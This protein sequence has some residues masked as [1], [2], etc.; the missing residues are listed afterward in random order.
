MTAIFF[1][2]TGES[3]FRRK[4]Y[5]CTSIKKG[6]IENRGQHQIIA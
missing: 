5:I 4:Q 6:K 1:A 3:M 2:Q